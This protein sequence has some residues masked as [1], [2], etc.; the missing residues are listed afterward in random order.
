MR[1]ECSVYHLVG[2]LLIGRYVPGS[3]WVKRGGAKVWCKEA[4]V[5][6]ESETTRL[7]RWLRKTGTKRTTVATQV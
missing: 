4:R 2:L 3:V 6:T 5:D 1:P 7:E